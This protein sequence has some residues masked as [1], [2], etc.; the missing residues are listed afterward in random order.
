MISKE[1]LSE[2]LKG[3]RYH[4]KIYG[5]N[6][7][8]FKIIIYGRD[9][10]EEELNIHELAHKCK[11][12]AF[13]KGYKLASYK[14]KNNYI[15]KDPFNGNEPYEGDDTEPEAIFKACEWIMDHKHGW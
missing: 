2:V 12:W 1:L 11:E 7:Q 3:E 9:F 4:F 15:C 8:H 13:I 14:S 6:N 10:Q 5:I